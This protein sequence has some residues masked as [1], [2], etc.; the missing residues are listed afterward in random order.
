MKDII[1]SPLQLALASRMGANAVL[2][3]QAVFDRGHCEQSLAQMITDAHARD[4]EVLLETHN[5]NE[6]RRAATSAADL[7]GINNRNLATLK[8]DLNVTKRI[9]KRSAANGKPVVSESGICKLA[10]LRFLRKCSANGFLI[11]SGVMLADDV[12]AKVREFV[13]A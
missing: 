4:L 3:I 1:I 2:M 10:D 7:I 8:V 6:F 9:L 11:G 5:I 13:D 12:E